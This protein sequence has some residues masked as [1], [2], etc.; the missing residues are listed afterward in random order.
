M[1]P[2]VALIGNLWN[3]SPLLSQ[4]IGFTSTQQ[5]VR[6][7]GSQVKAPL[8]TR[9]RVSLHLCQIRTPFLRGSREGTKEKAEDGMREKEPSSQE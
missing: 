1:F 4:M 9:R 6:Y 7:D 8:V 5:E 3:R 2:P